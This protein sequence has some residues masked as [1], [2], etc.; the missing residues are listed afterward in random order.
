[1]ILDNKIS[2]NKII[3]TRIL[4]FLIGTNILF[5]IYRKLSLCTD[6]LLSK[7]L[8]RKRRRLSACLSVFPFRVTDPTDN[9]RFLVARI[10]FLC[11]VQVN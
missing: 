6:C 9:E 5:I 3:F 11:Y 8:L 1:M 2:I 10:N 4:T 7:L